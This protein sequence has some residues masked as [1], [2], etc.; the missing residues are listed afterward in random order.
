MNRD[1]FRVQKL[2]CK[3]AHPF[4]LS[5]DLNWAG[6][7][8]EQKDLSNLSYCSSVAKG[9]QNHSNNHKVLSILLAL[10]LQIANA[11]WKL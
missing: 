9:T 8:A 6:G 5:N 10:S 7:P 3:V 2:L 4:M 11:N 1:T